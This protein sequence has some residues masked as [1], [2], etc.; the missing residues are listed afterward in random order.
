M[1]DAQTTTTT[2]TPVAETPIVETPVV[3]TTVTATAPEVPVEAPPQPEAAPVPAEPVLEVAPEPTP[4]VE[5]P[6]AQVAPEPVAPAPVV[7]TAPANPGPVFA[8][9]PVQTQAASLMVMTVNETLA[10]YLDVMAPGKPMDSKTG[11]RNQFAIHRLLSNVCNMTSGFKEAW[12]AVL[13]VFLA[14]KDGA[15]NERYIFRFAEELPGSVEDHNA[16][17]R[18]LNLIILTA[19]PATRQE[20]LLKVSVTRTTQEGFTEVARS[21]IQNYYK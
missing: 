16:F 4:V 5:A 21:N 11:A 14:N 1:T 19:D 6:V 7:E 9:A 2:E 8:T 3:E 13:A 20:N 10:K 15:M 12:D 17:Q 18:L